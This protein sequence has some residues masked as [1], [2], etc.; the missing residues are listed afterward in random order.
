M[1][2]SDHELLFIPGPTEVYPEILR[3][4]ARPQIGHRTAACR[5]LIGRVR[6]KLAPLFATRQHVLFESCP[7][8]ALMEAAI[9]NLVPARSLHLTCGAFSERWHKV[10]RACGR[11]ATA[12]SVEWGRANEPDDLHRA[13]E[14]ERF[15][16]VCITHNETSTGI[17]NPLPE[18]AAIVREAGGP[19]LLVDAVTSLAGTRLDFDALG[20]DLAFA[21]TQK[22]LALPGG[23]TVYALSERALERAATVPDRGWLLDF[24]RAWEGLEEGNSVATPSI[25]HLW[26]LDAQL[27][28]IADEGLEQRY[29]RHDSMAESLRAWARAHGLEMFGDPRYLSPTTGTVQA[30]RLDVAALVQALREK[31]FFISNGYG[32]LKG[33]TFRVGHMGDHGMP[34]LEALLAAMSAA[35]QKLYRSV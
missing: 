34:Q 32:P 1:G 4:L 5:E 21:S 27:D 10:A 7:A 30:G 19:L 35:V 25:P 28:R 15:D 12:V 26:A 14:G 3:E 9:R 6:R 29:A 11:E 13:L 17:L 16:A 33:K 22:C 18:L 23:F 20:L 31:G 8:T 2:R 24:V